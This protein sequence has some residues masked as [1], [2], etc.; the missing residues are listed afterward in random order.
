MNF[1]TIIC[2]PQFH[3][4]IQQRS[5]LCDSYHAFRMY[6]LRQKVFIDYSLHIRPY[7]EQCFQ[8]LHDAIV[9]HKMPMRYSTCQR[10]RP[11]YCLVTEA[12]FADNGLAT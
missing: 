7:V 11:L 8:L 6:D 9:T 2:L 10:L 5:S 1:Q 4:L 3:Y 12:T